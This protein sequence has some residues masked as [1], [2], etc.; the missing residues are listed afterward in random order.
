MSPVFY[1]H[2][3]HTEKTV[4]SGHFG[5]FVR[6]WQS[7]SSQIIYITSMKIATCNEL[8][9]ATKVEAAGIE[10]ASC[11]GVAGASTCVVCRLISSRAAQRTRPIRDQSTTVLTSGGADVGLMPA[12]LGDRLLDASGGPPQP[13]LRFTQPKQ[14]AV[15][16]L[17]CDQLFTWPADQPR[18]AASTTSSPVETDRP[19]MGRQRCCR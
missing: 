4:E 19:R 1:S 3:V 7:I 5:V 15:W 2:F 12:R 18:H 11:G 16:Q 17:C 14:I 6:D 13:G 10:P 9:A 8:Q